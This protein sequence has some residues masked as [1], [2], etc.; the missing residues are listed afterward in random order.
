MDK[1]AL[2]INEDHKTTQ[3]L[4]KTK[5]FTVSIADKEH[6]DVADFFGIATG[7]KMADKFERT[8]YNAVKSDVV[9]A[10]IID[11]FPYVMECELAEVINT[12]NMYAIVGKIVDTK[13][14]ESIL[15]ENDKV[16][17]E[18]LQALIFDQFKHGYYV[19]GD[20][21]GKAWNAGK[22]LMK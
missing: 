7:N 10:P 15:D 1:I 3:N 16:E 12:E 22:D 11:E 18:K 17:V 6:M 9:N 13:A 8:G 21:D 20:K 14:E 4:V 2:F 19:S 5:A